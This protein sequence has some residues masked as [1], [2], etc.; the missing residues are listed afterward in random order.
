MLTKLCGVLS[1]MLPIAIHNVK[2]LSMYVSCEIEVPTDI[3]V[4]KLKAYF[5]LTGANKYTECLT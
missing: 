4:W 5:T 1:N 3:S 2:W